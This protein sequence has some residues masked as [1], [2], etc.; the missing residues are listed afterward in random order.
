MEIKKFY[1]NK[2]VLITGV[3]GFKG[4]WLAI[5][6]HILGAK[7]LGV[8]K[9][10]PKKNSLFNKLGLKNKIELIF[11]DVQNFNKLKRVIFKRKPKIVFHLAAQTLIIDSYVNPKKTFDVNLI[12]TLNILEITRL[13]NFIKSLII[14]TSDKVYEKKRINMRFK[15]NDK[16]GGIDPYSASKA[17]IEFIIN[18]YQKSFFIKKRIGVSSVRSGNVIGGGD[19]SN[20]RLL[21][22][23]IKNLLKNKKI[24]IRN[25]NF[26][27]PWQFVMEPLRGYLILAKKQFKNPQK[28]AGAWNFGNNQ[29]TTTNVK[30]FVSYLI[31]LWG[32]GKLKVIKKQNYEQKNLQLDSSKSK[33]YLNWFPIYNIKQSIKISLEWYK[34]VLVKKANPLQVTLQQIRQYLDDC[35]IY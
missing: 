26:N 28:Y 5:F 4:S 33:K 6:L 25:A 7:V 10:Y 13:S 34:K 16:L 18:A 24:I 29:N 14:T 35:K 8:I 30:K 27:R 19:F 20:N 2:K 9:K 1:K 3:S 32:S 31:K 11:C 21:P 15:E 22:D 23:C 17:S 12:G